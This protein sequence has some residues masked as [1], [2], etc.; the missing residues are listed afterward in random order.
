MNAHLLPLLIAPLGAWG[1]L[2]L[3]DSAFAKSPS[4]YLRQFLS[5]YWIPPMEALGTA[6]EASV[7]DRPFPLYWTVGCLVLSA[8]M[9]FSD[10]WWFV[11][12]GKGKMITPILGLVIGALIF[13]MSATWM[14]YQKRHPSI[15]SSELITPSHFEKAARFAV[16][17]FEVVPMSQDVN[18][19]WIINLYYKNNGNIIG[20]AP[21][22]TSNLTITDNPL[23]EDDLNKFKKIVLDDS[24]SAKAAYKAQQVEINQEYWFTLPHTIAR[25]DWDAVR[26][27]KKKLYLA[28]VSKY[29]DDAIPAGA[30]WISEFCGMQTDN[31]DTTQICGFRTYLHE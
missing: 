24:L 17:R 16:T 27:G 3:S 19:P 11:R 7:N 21:I 23:S 6:M 14:I 31:T 30:F 4:D 29:Q 12:R 2:Y 8:A 20:Y 15:S 18:G 10:Y 22:V 9:G 5:W 26:A 13:F 25:A 28:A 1:G